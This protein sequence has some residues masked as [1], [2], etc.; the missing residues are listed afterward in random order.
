MVMLDKLRAV[1]MAALPLPRA[2]RRRRC[3]SIQCLAER[4][5]RYPV[6]LVHNPRY[7]AANLLIPG[8]RHLTICR[9]AR[10]I[11]SLVRELTRTEPPAG[12]AASAGAGREPVAA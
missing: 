11:G 4:N 6:L 3:G 2:L 7:G 1:G 5:A 12:P 9:D 8:C 10:L